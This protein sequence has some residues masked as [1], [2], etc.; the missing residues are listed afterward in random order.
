MEFLKKIF[1]ILS[2]LPAF[3]NLFK[4]AA[5][6]GKI[7]PLETLN[8]LS[9]IS[10]STKKVA[11]TAMSTAQQGGNVPAVMQ[12]LTNVGEVELMGQ[13]VNTKTMIQDLK[14]T[15]GFCSVLANMLEKMQG[16]SPEEIVAFGKEASNVKNWQDFVK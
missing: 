11:D 8:A 10:P 16:Q 12:A 1:S 9:T 13:K 7:D 3:T 2:T 14:K 5:Q 6:T 4:K 15:G